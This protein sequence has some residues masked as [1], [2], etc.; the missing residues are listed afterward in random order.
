MKSLDKVF[1][2]IELLRVTSELGLKDLSE[3]LEINKST[4]YRMLS[5]LVKH[6]Y[7]EKNIETKKYKLSIKFAEIGYQV[8]QNLDIIVAAK[9]LIDELNKATKETIH[10]AKLIGDE[11]VYIDKRES[12]SPIR[13]SSQIGRVV[14]W[15]CTGVGK[16]IL[17]FQP[18]EFRDRIIESLEFHVY[19]E[20]TISNRNDFEKEL[21]MI[22]EIGY[23]TD[24]EENQKNVGCIAAPIYDHTKKVVASISVTFIFEKLEEQLS[25]YK[26]LIIKTSMLMSRQLGYKY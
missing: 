13:L 16:A 12:L 25:R 26:D 4:T 14:L 9:E 19:T 7:V 18:K 11:V 15:H 2:I 24:R 10:L 22:K 1:K 20:N 3:K 8:I 23:A 21:E 5:S 6:N 17:A